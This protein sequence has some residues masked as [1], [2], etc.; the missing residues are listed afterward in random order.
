MS[1]I[2]RGHGDAA[3]IA[4]AARSAV[5]KADGDLPLIKLRTMHDVVAESI[6]IPRLLMQLLSGFAIFAVLLDAIGIYG[7]VDYLA[8]QRTREVGIRMA[9]GATYSSVIG[10]VLREGMAPAMLGAA[11]GIPVALGFSSVL[12][13]VLYGIGPRDLGVFVGASAVLLIIAMA[14]SFIPARRAANLDAMT[15]LRAE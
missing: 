12:N 9:L 13:A 8:R 15:A 1:I 4:G 10:S 6:S 2:V 11:V 3:S 7:I 5:H 14:A